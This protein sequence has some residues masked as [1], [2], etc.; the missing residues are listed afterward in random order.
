MATIIRFCLQNRKPGY[1]ED[2]IDFLFLGICLS[3]IE[4]NKGLDLYFIK[5]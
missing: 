5:L 4:N 1:A 3:D 2:I